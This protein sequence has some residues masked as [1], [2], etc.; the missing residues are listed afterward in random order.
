MNSFELEMRKPCEA[1]K[2][3]IQISLSKIEPKKLRNIYAF[4]E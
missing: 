4:M 1:M 2:E 3:R